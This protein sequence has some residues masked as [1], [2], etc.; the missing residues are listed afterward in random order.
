MKNFGVGGYS[1]YQAF[2]RMERVE[3]GPETASVIVLNIYDDDHFR[4][5]DALRS[6]RSPGTGQPFTL[7]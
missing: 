1:V 2:R 3:S 7:P 5:L 6:I 4:N